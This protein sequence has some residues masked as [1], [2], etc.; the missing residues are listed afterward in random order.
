MI[1]DTSKKPRTEAQQ[2]AD[3][4]YRENTK[5]SRQVKRVTFNLDDAQ[6]SKR[7]AWVIKQAVMSDAIKALIDKAMGEEE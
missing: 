5:Q 6:D 4:A 1:T 2:R 7:Y 3:G